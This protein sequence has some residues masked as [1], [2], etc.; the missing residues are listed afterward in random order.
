MPPESSYDIKYFK[1]EWPVPGVAHVEINRPEK[2]NAFNPDMWHGM[3]K[4][5]DRLSEDPNVRC[6][7]LSGNGEKA[8]CAGLDVQSASTAGPVSQP[9][10]KLDF[11]RRSWAIRRHVYDYQNTV[12]AIERCEKPT[13]ILLHGICFGAAI[14]MATAADI[15]YCTKDAKLCVKEV[16]VGLAAD[17][18]TLTRLPKIGVSYSWAKEI[19]YTARVF[20]GEEALQ[21]G[22]ASRNFKGKDELMKA[23]VELATF[24][25]SKSPVAVQ[26]S[27]ALLDFSRDR[28]IE[29]GLRYTASWNA[30]MVQAEDVT[31]A[32]MSGVRKTKPTFEKL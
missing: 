8:F 23:G 4:I 17:V 1:V 31:K 19:V 24:I 30:A 22:F 27:K 25:A 13:I 3:P 18:G 32:M 12:N 15:R 7:V 2:Y 20:D 5:F 16:D 11:A 29:D 26:S 9:D 21:V 14:D 6:I 28:P 10:P